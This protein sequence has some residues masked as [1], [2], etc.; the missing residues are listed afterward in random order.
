M[1]TDP[2][3]NCNFGPGRVTILYFSLGGVGLDLSAGGSNCIGSGQIKVA[4]GQHY[5][6]HSCGADTCVLRR[7]GRLG[8]WN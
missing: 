2:I 1:N 8:Y 5:V 3:L 6:G 7:D 4:H